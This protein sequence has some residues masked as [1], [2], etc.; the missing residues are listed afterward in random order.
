MTILMRHLFH[1]ARSAQIQLTVDALPSESSDDFD[2]AI[3]VTT[4]DISVLLSRWIINYLL[5]LQITVKQE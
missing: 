5:N 1:E 3:S 2:G 4:A